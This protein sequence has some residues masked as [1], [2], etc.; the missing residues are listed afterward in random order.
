MKQSSLTDNHFAKLGLD[1]ISPSVEDCPS[2]DQALCKIDLEHLKA[3][4]DCLAL[5]LAPLK[6]LSSFDTPTLG[7]CDEKKERGL[8]LLKKGSCG[9]ILIAGGEGSRLGHSGPKGTYIVTPP[10]KSLFEIFAKRV[11]EA[12]L[13]AQKELPFAIMTSPLND[14]QTRAFFKK[15]NYFGLSPRQVYFFTQK[16]LPNLNFQ[17]Q[18]FLQDHDAI[19]QGPDGN[20][21]C[22]KTFF[23]CGLGAVF[24]RLGVQYLNI[25]LVDNALAD[26]FDLELFGHLDM[27]Q[28]DIVLKSCQRKDPNEKVGVFL[29]EHGKLKVVEYH[30]MPPNFSFK[31][32]P[33]AN[34]SLM[35]LSFSFAQKAA[36]LTLPLH[37]AAKK[38]DF[39]DPEKKQ[40]VKPPTP[41]AW[42]F[43]YYLFDILSAA[44]QASVLT[45]P[46]EDIFSPLKKREDLTHV[47]KTLELL[48]KKRVQE[49]TSTQV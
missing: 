7:G 8:D 41:N 9:S 17:G 15:N 43:E 38:V 2:I 3:Q 26:P 48:N 5:S 40:I 42:K 45:Y 46:R 44:S 20:G 14:L 32:E 33:C 1:H 37:K 16:M 12:S 23:E 22:L 29:Q 36:Q 25:I 34:L 47:Q 10:Q 24:K 21:H 11:Q 6:N 30:E 13:L 35:A 39:Y 28:D 49:H 27:T 19:A 31:T 4:R 18:L